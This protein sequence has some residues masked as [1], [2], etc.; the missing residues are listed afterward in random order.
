MEEKKAII[1]LIMCYLKNLVMKTIIL[2]IVT[3]LLLN[4]TSFSQQ[5]PN[6][7]F[8][9][10]ST[11]PT[12]GYLPT[13]WYGT[14]YV[15]LNYIGVTRETDNPMDGTYFVKLTAKSQNV[16]GT[17]YKAPGGLTLSDL[18]HA[19]KVDLFKEG[20]PKAGVA[21]T[22]RPTRLTGFYKY[23]SINNDSY[24]MSVALTKWRGTTRDTI[25]YAENRSSQTVTDWTKF[26]LPI[27]YR[28]QDIP[29]TLN[30]VFLTTPVFKESDL[31]KVQ[32]GST[33]SLDKL[34]FIMEDFFKVDFSYTGNPCTG[35]TLTFS[36]TSEN[37][38][39]DSWEWSVN[40]V[41]AGNGVTMT[42]NFPEVEV[43]TNFNVKL[44]GTNNQIG[45][46]EITKVI[47]IHP[48]PVIQLLPKDPTICPKSA[49]TLTA[50]GGVSYQWNTA[51]SGSQIT[52]TPQ[53]YALYQVTGTD[54][55]GCTNSASSMIFYHNLDT[56]TVTAQ[57]C[58]NESYDFHGK[59]LTN[60]GTYFH[61]F[62]SIRT[63]CDS[64][65]RLVLSAIPTPI[66]TLTADKD[67]IC[68][69][70]SVVLTAT[71]GMA[72]Y[73]WGDGFVASNT[74]TVIP[75][76]IQP[77]T[78]IVKSENGC[79][80]TLNKAIGIFPFVITEQKVMI[81]QGDSINIFGDWIKAQGT[82]QKTYA[83]MN[84]C[85]SISIINVDVNLLPAQFAVEGSGGYSP[86]KE[87]RS[88]IQ[89]GS[90]DGIIYR[91]MKNG[92]SIK[93]VTGNGGELS[94]GI[95]P[96][97]QYLIKAENA[98]T[99]CTTVMNDTVVISLL[100]GIDIKDM[101]NGTAIYPNPANDKVYI[102]V[103]EKSSIRFFNNS[104]QVI[105]QIPEFQSSFINVQ[106]FASGIYFVEI[107]GGRGSTVH[108]LIKK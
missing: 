2:S 70:S 11:R 27:Q 55:Y 91:L 22:A 78:V 95:H 96:A 15:D 23:T 26:E 68:T 46:D 90:E 100:V 69:G 57:F 59:E 38:P 34:E 66:A 41:N 33:L 12:W 53:Q 83:N 25:G 48:R 103:S 73:D 98:T 93:I 104:G 94:F 97:G 72:G 62:P 65:I 14:N 80:V 76:T 31:S 102:Y 77:F 82:F 24:Y 67:A 4:L 35:G 89:T 63:G 71:P 45:N 105:M 40:G 9:N 17:T 1:L 10:W 6:A 47:T 61:N 85:D 16:F 18:Y 36:A 51:G 99:G 108:K 106:S 8:E 87:G 58:S 86:D 50:T 101:D 21:Y 19:T 60:P 13:S 42:Y 43:S 88:I 81:C 5:I 56:T 107:V 92:E 37:V 3:I 44:K 79:T 29:D 74:L 32:V 20:K 54:Q 7:S 52:V 75:E 28:S 64:T 49:I 39:G 84:G 30:I